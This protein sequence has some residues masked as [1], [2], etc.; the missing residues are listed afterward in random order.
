M[1]KMKK[2][3][4]V[5]M[6]VILVLSLVA[7]PVLASPPDN[8]ASGDWC[9]ALADGTDVKPADGNL[10]ILDFNDN[11][12]WFGTFSGNSNDEGW[13]V[14]RDRGYWVFNT[15]VSFDE[16]AVLGKIGGLEMR[17]NG[18]IPA[19]APFSEYEGTWVITK[20]LGELRGLRG[21]GT[22]DGGPTTNCEGTD[23]PFGVPYTG[24]V[25]YKNE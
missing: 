9:Y 15:T 6:A 17:V 21:H 1:G 20:A 4:F 7:I 14:I 16:V 8:N 2:I 11:G 22:W 18:R 10:F 12:K 25:H 24:T 13:I 19:G 3:L 23:F 5:L